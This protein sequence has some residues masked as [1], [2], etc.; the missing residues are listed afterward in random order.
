MLLKTSKMNYTTDD[1]F[2]NIYTLQ[3]SFRF[4]KA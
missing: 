4:S 3:L 1:D 2:K